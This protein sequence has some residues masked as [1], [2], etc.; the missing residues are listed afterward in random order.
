MSG[1]ISVPFAIASVLFQG[2]ERRILALL[3]FITLGYFCYSILK[4]LIALETPI[5]EIACGEDT[6]DSIT[7][8]GAVEN[9]YIDSRTGQP[10]VAFLS[11]ADFFGFIVSNSGR[12]PAIKCQANLV[13]LEKGNVV[14]W[15]KITALSFGPRSKKEVE[16]VE[17]VE[18][19]N[20][21]PRPA[22]LVSVNDREEVMHGSL[23][24]CWKYHIPFHSFF[25]EPGEYVFTVAVSSGNIAK[26]KTF[27]AV[28]LWSGKKKD[29]KI[30]LL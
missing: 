14:L 30:R 13:K 9:R 24:Q 2:T 17:E 7:R 6:P 21:V 28:F 20:G 25:K 29:S 23:N 3:A 4:R 22:A 15:E 12:E 1:G 27:R 19:R 5:L 18:I 8:D 10:S 26:T 11:K 16:P